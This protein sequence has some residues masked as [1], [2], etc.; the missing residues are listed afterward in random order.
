MAKQNLVYD[1]SDAEMLRLGLIDESG[2]LIVERRN[3]YKEYMSI[4]QM[5]KTPIKQDAPDFENLE[6]F[7]KTKEKIRAE[8]IAWRRNLFKKLFGRNK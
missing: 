1:G 7:F 3:E 4:V 2:S 6:E 8:R 5:K